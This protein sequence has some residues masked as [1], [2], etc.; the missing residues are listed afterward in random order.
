M[1]KSVKKLV[2]LSLACLMLLGLT[3]CGSKEAPSA[4]ALMRFC[5]ALLG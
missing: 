5:S 3:A 1:R 2:A 4:A